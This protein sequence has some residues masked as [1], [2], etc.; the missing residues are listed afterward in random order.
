MKSHYWILTIAIVLMLPLLF[1]GCQPAEDTELLEYKLSLSL[2]ELTLS[3]LPTEV[4]SPQ[5]QV[6]TNY[7]DWEV[8]SNAEWLSAVRQGSGIL[9][10]ARTTNSTGK[11]RQADVLVFAGTEVKKVK[12]T[13]S[14]DKIVLEVSPSAI[15]VPAAGATY[16]VDLANA[17]SDV[18]ITV[19]QE[20]DWVAYRTLAHKSVM[21]VTVK[22]NPDEKDREAKI[23]IT[24]AGTPKELTIVQKGL[25][26]LK[27]LPYL[28]SFSQYQEII[29][30]EEARGARLVLFDTPLPKHG[31][32][33]QKLK[34]ILPSTYFGVATY[35]RQIDDN[36]LQT[37]KLDSYRGDDVISDDFKNYLISEGFKITMWDDE[38]NKG[39]YEGENAELG[40]KF[41][42]EYSKLPKKAFNYAALTFTFYPVQKKEFKTFAQFPYYN[43]D[44]LNKSSYEEVNTWE[45]AQGSIRI[46]SGFKKS[47]KFDEAYT[48][49][50]YKKNPVV[51]HHI[52]SY[53]HFWYVEDD[54]KAKKDPITRSGLVSQ[55]W[56][57]HDNVELAFW[58]YSNGNYRWAVTKEFEKLV[59]D[60][61][62]E[63]WGYAGE[64]GDFPVYM[65]EEK[66]LLLIAMVAMY[67]DMQYKPVLELVYQKV[68]TV[69]Y[70]NASADD[71]K[72]S[73]L[74]E[75]SAQLTQELKDRGAVLRW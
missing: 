25:L 14:A 75:L 73:L 55:L 30:F 22:A 60:E 58:D 15:T 36:L 26:G 6:T 7:A 45:L 28:K 23:Y 59:A 68:S 49:A 39:K 52:E 62:Y 40:Y 27:I 12:V 4:N 57:T 29:A 47:S 56:C 19:E 35:E 71:T 8:S 34:F 64:A 74:D 24:S 54:S 46:E 38:N 5:V 11:D 16:I 66:D 10:Q 18:S 2:T 53:Y 1:T 13:Q 48:R 20:G 63:L 69:D 3:N 41:T 67:S 33:R 50:R 61:G 65:N 44:M 42:I 43:S 21:E 72:E 70:Q 32:Y 37:I 31:M 17:Q 9:I 51:N